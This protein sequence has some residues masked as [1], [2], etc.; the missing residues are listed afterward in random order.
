MEKP[1]LQ[2]IAGSVAA[3]E[4]WVAVGAV[5]AGMAAKNLLLPCLAILVLFWPLRRIVHGRWSRR[6]PLDWPVL[7]LLAAAGITLWATSRPEIT[8]PQVFRLLAGVGFYYAVANAIDTPGAVRLA[9]RGLSLAGV[10][11]ALG[12]L[13]SVDWITDK[14]PFIPARIY[15]L[16]PVRFGDGIHPNVMAGSLVLLLPIAAGIFLWEKGG[17]Q[18]LA[19]FGASSAMLVVL[20]LTQSRA[21]LAAAAAALALLLILRY[22]VSRWLVPSVLAAAGLAAWFLAPAGWMAELFSQFAERGLAERFDI[23]A[24][25]IYMIQDFAFTGIGMGLYEPVGDFLYPFAAIEPGST[26]H[27][28]NLFIQV[29]LDLGVLGLVA[30]G[31]C[32]VLA[33]AGAVQITRWA[34]V[35]GKDV[36]GVCAGL[37]AGQAALVVHGLSDAVTW[38][39]VRTA[40]LVWGLWGLIAAMWI[41][42]RRDL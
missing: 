38:G 14:L 31:S 12:A 16:L 18:R 35:D 5:L 40:P 27:A 8:F 22:P 30:W 42:G 15:A 20:V 9:G 13:V 4:I 19:G 17:L 33:L 26:P 34:R 41:L 7:L 29:G 10:G 32:L 6:T 21:G 25:G 28:H 39:M 11:L 1:N 3:M 24:R 36:V 37:L 23:W 2:Q